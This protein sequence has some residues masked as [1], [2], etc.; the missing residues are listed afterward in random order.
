[1]NEEEKCDDEECTCKN[2]N[3][4]KKSYNGVTV[5]HDFH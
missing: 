3:N 4:E 5:G 2:H 1:M